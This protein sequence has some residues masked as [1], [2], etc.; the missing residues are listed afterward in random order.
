MAL[1]HTPRRYDGFSILLHWTIALFTIVLFASGIWM[2]DLGY[3]DDWYYE[4]PWWHKGIGVLTMML[5]AT[6]WIWQRVRTSPPRILSIADWQHY[7]ALL[8]HG[9]MNLSILIL[10]VSG[11]LIVTAK[12]DPLAVFDW[13]SIP[14]LVTDQ[15]GWSDWTGKAH[16]WSGWFVIILA[17]LHALAALKHHFID[18]DGTLKRMLA[19]KSGEN[20]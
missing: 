7:T 3:Y 6:R 11:Y 15:Q 19:I 10:F 8:V 4:A 18:R 5:V 17:S 2:V 1:Q 13:F 16:R 9:L 20:K 14:A 12:G